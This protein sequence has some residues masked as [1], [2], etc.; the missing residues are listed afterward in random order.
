MGLT[1]FAS[2][3]GALLA[4][5]LVALAWI[6]ARQSRRVYRPLR[7]IVTHPDAHGYAYEEV[8]LHAADGTRLKGW[9]V[10]NPEACRVLMFFHGNTRNISHCMDSLALF[11]RLG[12]S[13]MLFDYRGYGESEGSPAEDGTYLDAQAAWEYLLR[14]R[15]LAPDDIVVLGRSL[16]AAI[17]SW[18]AARHPPRALVIESTFTSLPDVAA[19]HHPWLPAR[20]LARYRYPVAEH[21]ARIRCPVLIVHSRADEIVPFHHAERLLGIAPG[22]KELLEIEGMHYNGYRT[23]GPRYEEGLAAFFAKYG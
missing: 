15:G 2:I 3:V 19:D 20:V 17:A 6:Y 16:G 10:P 21:L 13:V 7:A 1:L 4:G 22:P 12:F 5:Y 18:L 14:E 11:H 23:S 9:F 8:D